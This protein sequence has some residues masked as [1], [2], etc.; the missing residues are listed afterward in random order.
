MANPSAQLS[1]RSS[2][3]IQPVAGG[4]P[5]QPFQF[6]SFPT[7]FFANMYGSAGPTPG[8]IRVTNTGTIVNLTQLNTFGGMCEI[9][10]TDAVNTLTWGVWVPTLSLFVPVGDIWAQEFYLIR[11]SQYLQSEEPGTGTGTYGLSELMLRSPKG[12]VIEAIVNA[13]D[14]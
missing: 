10:N 7:S 5:P 14:M 13:F 8:M 6:R 9:I 1:I 2:L 12:S 11:L 3:Q 4:S